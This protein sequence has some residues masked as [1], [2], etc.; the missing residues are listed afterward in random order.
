MLL[1]AC[2]VVQKTSGDSTSTEAPKDSNASSASSPSEDKKDSVQQ[3][4]KD[5]APSEDYLA[6]F[7]SEVEEGNYRNA[8]EI[9]ENYFEGNSRKEN[10]AYDVL[11][12]LINDSLSQYTEGTMTEQDFLNYLTTVEKIDKELDIY[13]TG[14]ARS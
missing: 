9:Y 5:K 11:Y 3:D 12:E 10:S 14:Y 7:K 6:A 4:S 8:I 1:S 13:D 2:S